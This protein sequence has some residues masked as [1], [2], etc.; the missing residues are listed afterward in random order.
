MRFNRINKKTILFLGLVITL[1]GAWI[2]GLLGQLYRLIRY[3][4]W[5]D[6][7]GTKIALG[8]L[9]MTIGPWVIKGA[10]YLRKD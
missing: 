2:T 9:L 5:P 4:E 3:G 6:M 1:I 8:S 10:Y 7:G